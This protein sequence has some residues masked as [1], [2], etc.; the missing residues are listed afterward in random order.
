MLSQFSR[1]VKVKKLY[2]WKESRDPVRKGKLRQQPR[3][4]RIQ[5][6]QADAP[7][8]SSGNQYLKTATVKDIEQVLKDEGFQTQI[9]TQ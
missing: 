1:S 9:A 5:L 4:E 6:M 2:T 3:H 7:G 8:E